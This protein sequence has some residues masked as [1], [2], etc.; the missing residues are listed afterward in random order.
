MIENEKYFEFYF[1]KYNYIYKFVDPVTADTF[2][3]SYLLVKLI[4]LN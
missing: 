1:E 2:N 3:I 4:T